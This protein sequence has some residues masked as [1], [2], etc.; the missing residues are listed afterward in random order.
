MTSFGGVDIPLQGAHA[1]QWYPEKTSRKIALS[2]LQSLHCF[3]GEKLTGDPQKIPPKRCDSH[4][5]NLST[6]CV[7]YMTWQPILAMVEYLDSLRLRG[8]WHLCEM[9]GFAME[10]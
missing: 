3:F 5:W 4:V 1:Q 2:F 9:L 7:T 10:M 6:G 8:P